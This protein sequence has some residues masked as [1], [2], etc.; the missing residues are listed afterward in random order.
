MLSSSSTRTYALTARCGLL[1]S[2]L[3][4]G[5]NSIVSR[6]TKLFFAGSDLR[7]TEKLNCVL[8][9]NTGKLEVVF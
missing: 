3:C 8:G 1:T 2:G 9:R 7:E 5:L 6:I 4:T